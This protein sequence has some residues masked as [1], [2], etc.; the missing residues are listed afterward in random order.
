[1]NY[2]Q[3]GWPMHHQELSLDAQNYFNY[4]DVLSMHQGMVLKGFHI[5]IPASIHQ[6]ILQKL[7]LVLPGKTKIHQ[8]A[9]I[10]VFWPGITKDIDVLV[11]SCNTCQTYCPSN[12]EINPHS[13]I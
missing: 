12:P 11:D 1:M 9:H 3:H 10:S 4:R 13:Q 2:I 8:R 7:Q 6:E 5:I